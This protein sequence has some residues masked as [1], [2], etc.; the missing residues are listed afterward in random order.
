MDYASFSDESRHSEGRYRSIAAVSLPAELVVGISKQLAGILDCANCKELK[1][2]SVGYRGTRDVN[3]AIA[4]VDFL[5]EHITNGVRADALTWDTSDERHDVPNRDD[6]ANYERMFYHLHHALMERRGSESRWHIRPDEQLAI[7]WSTVQQCLRSDGTWRYGLDDSRLSND[8]RLVIPAVRTFRTVDSAETP[9]CQLADLLA[10]MAAYTRTKYKVMK[11]L[12]HAILGQADL[13]QVPE[14][15]EPTRRDRSRFQVIDH[16][17]RQCK[18]RKLGVSLR[19]YGYL[20][21]RNPKN[22]INFWHYVPQHS[23]DKAP[24]RELAAD[25]PWETVEGQR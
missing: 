5:L 13:F 4:A 21:T 2:G 14:R 15:T 17:D 8:F 23:R 12:M 22:P 24:A 1:W 20:Y 11:N 7:D 3:R 9:L 6:I 25:G 16:F 10:G 18:S 19:E